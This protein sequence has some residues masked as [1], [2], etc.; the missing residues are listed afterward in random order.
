M[1]SIPTES[2]D[3]SSYIDKVLTYTEVK[4]EEEYGEFEP[5]MVKFRMMRNKLVELGYLLK[6]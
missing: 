6:N 1:E 4:F 5:V 3:L 2:I